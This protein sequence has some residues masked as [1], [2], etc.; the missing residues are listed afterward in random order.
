MSLKPY[1]TSLT[2]VTHETRPILICCSTVRLLVTPGLWPS[3][4]IVGKAHELE[5]RLTTA[6][7]FARGDPD[8][9]SFCP[10]G[11]RNNAG[12]VSAHP[13][14]R[15]GNGEMG[16][17]SDTGE[18]TAPTP[19]R[20]Q[21]GPMGGG[22]RALAPIVARHSLHTQGENCSRSDSLTRKQP[23]HHQTPETC[24]SHHQIIRNYGE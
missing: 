13:S 9:P 16:K 22:R 7:R 17:P 5:A 24:G 6:T 23:L 15:V 12:V 3:A 20:T 8:P 2:C 21:T 10:L 14:V 11:R 4:S 1:D 18:V 19:S